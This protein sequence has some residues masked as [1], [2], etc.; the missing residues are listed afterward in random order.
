[1][2]LRDAASRFNREMCARAISTM[3]RM[4]I[5]PVAVGGKQVMPP[6]RT[7]P[8][9]ECQH[10]DRRG[11]SDLPIVA[12]M[13]S[14]TILLLTCCLLMAC[15]DRPTEPPSDGDPDAAHA[16]DASAERSNDATHADHCVPNVYEGK[17]LPVDIFV[18]A[19]ASDAANCP[20]GQWC[21]PDGGLPPPGETRWSNVTSAIERFA[22]APGGSSVGL[23]VF[24]R[25]LPMSNAVS[26]VAEDYAPPDLPFGA[27]ADAVANL[28][29][30]RTPRGDWLL[31]VPLGGALL[32]ARTHAAAHPDRQTVVA[33]V[34]HGSDTIVCGEDIFI[35]RQVASEFFAA[36]PSIKTAIIALLP[37][38]GPLI[39]LGWA[40]GSR[41]YGINRRSLDA[42]A[43]TLAALH[44]VAAPCN[45]PVPATPTPL[46]TRNALGL[47]VRLGPA[48]VFSNSVRVD[49]AEHCP[50]EAGGW[51]AN[52]NL[53]PTR[54]TFCP[55]ICQ[56]ITTTPGSAVQLVVGCSS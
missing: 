10:N 56:S 22:A 6:S 4:G 38:L 32:Y 12:T 28:L 50:V 44:E 23:G 1:M 41:V 34:T 54:V 30:A 37:C 13:R 11:P 19:D 15:S 18:V 9:R 2:R 31:Q 5:F 33:L 53:N 40:G 8:R 20:L 7:A 16:I 21:L 39:E 49:G 42:R 55:V 36:T 24:P 46:R 43:E 17:P 25:F 27:S 48:G 29:G 14:R 47:Q 35:S 3:C 52:N 45:F 26:C 51:F